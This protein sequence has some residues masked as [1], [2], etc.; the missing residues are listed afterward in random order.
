MALTAQQRAAAASALDVWLEANRPGHTATG[1]TLLNFVDK[2]RRFA[3][4]GVDM[5]GKYDMALAP[6]VA[7]LSL[8]NAQK[9]A[10][11]THCTGG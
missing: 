4:A 9:T 1:L 5:N 6:I 8:T 3:L 7:A 2:L 10:I 11:R